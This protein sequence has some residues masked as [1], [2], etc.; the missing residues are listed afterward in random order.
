MKMYVIQFYNLFSYF[1]VARI[2]K[3]EKSQVDLDLIL[4]IRVSWLDLIHIK[5]CM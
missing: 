3:T 2:M 4:G 1:L 5:N